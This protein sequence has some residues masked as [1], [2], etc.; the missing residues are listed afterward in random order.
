MVKAMK[1]PGVRVP[2]I[3]WRAPTYITVPPTTPN[4]EVADR[5]IRE[6]AVSDFST[7]SSRR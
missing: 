5:L 4:S 2:A 6:M 1:S 7:L 3:I